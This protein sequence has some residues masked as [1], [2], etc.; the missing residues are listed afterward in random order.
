MKLMVASDLHGSV[1]WTRK[2][3]ERF[4]EEQADYLVLLGDLLYHGPRNPLPKEY[5]PQ[6][7]I[8]LLNSI[9]HH[10][11]AVRG[12]C[13]SEVDQ[14]VLEFPMTADYQLIPMGNRK[15]MATHGHLYEDEQ[16]LRFLQK[17]D[18]MIFGHI[19]IPVLR[20]KE[21]IY[22]L[23]PGSATLPKEDHP[24]TYAILNNNL[25]EVKTFDGQVY[26]QLFL[27]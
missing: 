13:D 9:K 14:M 2:V 3:I 17:G 22:Y 27:P 8:Q 12:N 23:N 15:L 21:G 24:Q 18:V 10:I 5:N 19:H 26:R 11:I 1:Y 20:E 25:F 16:I 4:K 6:E 7:V